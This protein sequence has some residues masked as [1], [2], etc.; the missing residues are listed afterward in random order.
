MIQTD[1]LKT[2]LSRYS[3]RAVADEAG[4]CQRTIYRIRNGE[5]STTLATAEKLLG[6]IRRLEALG[7]GA[8]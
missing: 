8:A 3:A 2:L 4:I 1:D 6:A 7:K 5:T